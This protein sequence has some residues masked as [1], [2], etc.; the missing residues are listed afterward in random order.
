LSKLYAP[1]EP[2]AKGLMQSKFPRLFG[3]DYRTRYLIGVAMQG[4]IAGRP[5]ARH[6]GLDASRMPE[7]FRHFR[8]AG[9][10]TRDEAG[11][12]RISEKF[13]AFSELVILLRALGG[14]RVIVVPDAGADSSPIPKGCSL[15]GSPART[16]ILAVL[17]ASEA[18]S[19]KD[20]CHAAWCDRATAR[21][22]LEFFEQVGCVRITRD[23]PL[24]LA[25]LEPRFTYH[26]LLR[27]LAIRIADGIPA[28]SKRI[29]MLRSASALAI[30]KVE[31]ESEAA[32]LPFGTAIQSSVLLAASIQ[33]GSIR[34]VSIETGVSRNSVR[35]AA[36]VLERYGLVV[37]TVLGSGPAAT[38][39]IAINQ[40]HPLFAP[41]V[42]YSKS[43]QGRQ[44]HRRLPPTAI[45]QKRVT[46][47]SGLPGSRE[48]RGMILREVYRVGNTTASEVARRLCIGSHS[49]K[50]WARQL[51]SAGLIYCEPSR[52]KLL[53]SND[54]ARRSP[55]FSALIDATSR[56]VGHD[57]GRSRRVARENSAAIIDE[58]AKAKNLRLKRSRR[59]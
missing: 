50:S 52:G 20:L 49:I 32:L 51:H 26:E 17:A 37:T 38:R 56:F 27:R 45:R 57:F 23:P 25:S 36:D 58:L 48:L 13:A 11:L 35:T 46:S 34:E 22:I 41:L 39:W 15:F 8:K 3:H 2:G 29:E 42:A 5:L 24:I 18:I 1:I 47:F 40:A 14:E 21:S 31:R 10:V 12:L 54:V 7:L 9:V 28:V 53:L 30:N 59:R 19:V 43:L 55:E 4:P 16:R 33:P 6:L 44:L